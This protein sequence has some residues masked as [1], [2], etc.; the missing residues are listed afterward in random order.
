MTRSRKNLLK[1]KPFVIFGRGDHLY[2]F[3]RNDEEYFKVLCE[4]ICFWE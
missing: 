3:T 2:L 1:D 4:M